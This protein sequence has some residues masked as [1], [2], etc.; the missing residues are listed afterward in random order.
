MVGHID[1]ETRMNPVAVGLVAV[2]AGVAGVLAGW[3]LA[4]I[5]QALLDDPQ[6]VWENEDW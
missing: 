4:V 2:I 1:G 3:T 6:D 5:V